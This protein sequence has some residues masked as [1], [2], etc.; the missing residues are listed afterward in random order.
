M[1]KSESSPKSLTNQAHVSLPQ[2]EWRRVLAMAL[3]AVITTSSRAVMDVTDYVMVARL[4]T[5][6]AQ[7]AILPAQVVMWSYIVFGLGVVTMVNTFAA[8]AL[9]RRQERES[10]AYA[11]QA[12]YVAVF[13]GLLAGAVIGLVSPVIRWIG[14]EP[15]VQ[16]NEIA[17]MRVALLTTGPT[18]IA[19]GLGWFFIGIHRPK[20]PM[21]AALESVVINIVVSGSLIFG[22]MGMPELGIA[23]AAWGTL[24]AV[25]YRMI[26]LLAG[27]L[28]REVHGVYSSRDT[29]PP[30]ASRMINLFRVG[31][32][33]GLQFMSEVVV[34]AIF[35]NLLI[36]KRFG[37][38]HLIATNAAWQY[39]RIAF[40]PTLGAG[41]AL[42]AMVGKSIGEGH[43]ERAK[44]E[45]RIAVIVTTGY[46]LILSLIYVIFG[47]E[48][49]HLLTQ[50]DDA[51]RIGGTVMIFASIFQLFDAWAITYTASL[52][53]AGDTFI[54]SIFFV[55]S[56]WIIIVAGGWWIA[57]TFPHWQSLGPWVAASVLIGVT[58]FFLIWRWY[59]D[60]WQ[61]IDL[62][63]GSAAIPPLPSA[64]DRRSNAMKMPKPPT[65]KPH[66][67]TLRLAVL[68]SGGGRSLLNLKREIDEGR[69]PAEIQIVVS[70][71]S[72]APGVERARAAGLRVVVADRKTLSADQFQDAITRA[73]EGVDL[74]VMAGFLSK[75]LI[76]PE[77]EGRVINIHP[78]LLPEF[79]GNGMYGGRVHQAV[80][81]SGRTESGCTVHYCNNE[82]DRGPV[83]L[84]RYVPVM[85]GD[86]VDSLAARVF[87]Q[88]C[89]ALP[90]AIRQIAEGRVSFPQ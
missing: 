89:L 46:M 3:P 59:S 79:G 7:A 72:N 57:D 14:H 40:L 29:W 83:I 18:L 31:I 23:G 20:V 53:G 15:G 69:L 2:G 65:N 67:K 71:R 12:M 17:Y 60:A 51:A 37:T 26:R 28:S 70:S 82:Y 49:V 50:N 34:W 8:Q 61:K 48:L 35:V 39:M 9:G 84:Q 66:T 52:R 77:F 58:A 1:T 10:S 81:E 88:E 33:C 4:P 16:A 24:V 19:E 6:D 38:H 54:P 73:V 90:E 75:W 27:F 87:E 74:V 47:E 41:R 55:L 78:A 43:P 68:I 13:F 22:W 30:S 80:I 63:R 86:T 11:W 25:S 5:A 45:T 62:F 36:G 56:H 64:D 32:P 44:R 85:P 42:T 76:P 21:W